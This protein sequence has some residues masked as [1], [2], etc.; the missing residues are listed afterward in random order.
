MFGCSKF[1][2][3][4][5]LEHENVSYDLLTEAVM[6]II[7]KLSTKYDAEAIKNKSLQETLIA[8]QN[9]YNSLLKEHEQLSERHRQVLHRNT[10]ISSKSETSSNV[11]STPSL[12]NFANEEPT[13]PIPPSPVIKVENIQ[14]ERLQQVADSNISRV[15]ISDD[16]EINFNQSPEVQSSGHT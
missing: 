5:N 3:V 7:Y 9:K 8:S 1:C 11:T 14:D 2:S 16:D 4:F 10:S 13:F 6:R 15:A 12:L